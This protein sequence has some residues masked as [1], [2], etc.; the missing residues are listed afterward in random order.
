MSADP[1][2]SGDPAR[3]V[4]DLADDIAPYH[5]QYE[6][7]RDSRAVFAF[8]YYNLT[9]D[10]AEWLSADADSFDDP[11]WVADLAVAFG[12]RFQAAMDAIDELERV[13]GS[14]AVDDDALAETVSRPWADV[15]RAICRERSTVIEDLVFSIGAHITY[16]LPHALLAVDTGVDRLADYHLMNEVLASRTDAI[17]DAVTARYN[18]PMA[19]LDR[20]AGG[21]DEVFTNYWMRIGRSLAWYNAMRLS[22]PNSHDEAEGS[23]ERST[24][25]L[26]ESVRGGH[27]IVR[28][29]LCVSR[30][31]VSLTRQ[32]PTP[33]L[34]AADE[35]PP[36]EVRW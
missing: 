11:S 34:S 23:I 9:L 26:V 7:D 5:R 22:S 1:R 4:G 10:L 15:Y 28:S 13:G 12:D 20:L 2:L 36:E 14:D 6:A 16:D 30:V 17:Q 33:P 19:R 27:W 8:A 18:R 32:W 24:A 31:V 29:G 35:R 3:R 21:A 25:G